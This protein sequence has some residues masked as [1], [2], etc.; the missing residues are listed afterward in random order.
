MGVL[1][2]GRMGGGARGVQVWAGR[3][4]PGSGG[5][6]G[7]ERAGGRGR[8]SEF[9]GL[10]EGPGGRALGSCARGRGS[11]GGT[12]DRKHSP[13]ISP[14]ST[15]RR[16]TAVQLL[17]LPCP[18]PLPQLPSSSPSLLI[19]DWNKTTSTQLV[20]VVPAATT[21]DDVTAALAPPATARPPTPTPLLPGKLVLHFEVTCPT[22][23][24]Q[25]V[26]LV[27]GVPQLGDW[28]PAQGLVLT[29]AEESVWS[30]AAVMS[31]EQMA[32][33]VE[34]KVCVCVCVKL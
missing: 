9:W 20:E 15:Q 24:G 11:L 28:D 7:Q 2:G 6:E 19:C 16:T 23:P 5:R 29:W 8:G 1:L 33:G 34:A 22:Q 31:V 27:G 12:E 21:A 17:L 18:S 4:R 30:G 25:A 3:G 32:A 14:S 10:W 26:M 13:P